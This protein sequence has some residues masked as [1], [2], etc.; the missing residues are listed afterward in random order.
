MKGLNVLCSVFLA[1]GLLYLGARLA[2]KYN[3][4]LF[5]A[6]ALVHGT[7]FI[8]FPAYFF[9]CYFLLRP[10]FHRMKPLL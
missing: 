7:A 4:P 1:C 5:H 3:L 10:V 2:E 6:W 8:L 9:A